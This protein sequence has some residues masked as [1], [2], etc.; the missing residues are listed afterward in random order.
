MKIITA[1]LS[2]LAMLGFG[3]TAAQAQYPERPLRLIVPFQAGG[4]PD[5]MARGY[6]ERLGAQL[7]QPIVVEN[8]PG[9]TGAIG[10][11]NLLRSAPDGHTL[12]VNSSAMTIVPW[13]VKQSFD[14]LDDL[15]AVARTADTPYVITIHPGLPIQNLD[16][17]IEYARKHPGELSCATYG[18]AS[19]PH[20]ALELLKKAADIDIL[21]VPYK[22]FAQ[23]LPDLSTGRLSCSIDPPTAL[24]PHIASGTIRA[25]AHT[26]SRPLQA[27]PQAAALGER[28]PETEVIGWQGIFVHAKTPA[29]IVERLR[30]EWAD[31]LADEKVVD[32]I[33]VSGFEP[34]GQGVDDFVETIRADHQRFGQIIAERG[35][36]LD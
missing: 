1:A 27:V 7:K 22:G 17:F 29:P 9:A 5:T 19:P 10:S 15:T 14:A 16:D 30:A 23:T 8:R 35:I 12:L 4:A 25:I 31:V 6:A 2:A 18:V 3:A 13:V 21:H 32:L 33:R 28:Y 11:E 36:R 26:G 34:A 20:L 24:L